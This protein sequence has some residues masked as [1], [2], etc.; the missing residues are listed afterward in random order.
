MTE[1]ADNATITALVC[2]RQLE[3]L[4]VSSSGQLKIWDLRRPEN[5][6]ARVLLMC[7][8]VSNC[9]TYAHT[10]T[11]TPSSSLPTFPSL[12][13]SSF[14]Q[15]LSLLT[16]SF[17]LSLALSSLSLLLCPP[18]Y[19][20]LSSL[21]P[22]CSSGEHVGLHCLDRHP[23]QPHLVALGRSDGSVG[24]WDLRQEGHHLQI[25]EAH[26]SIGTTRA[27]LTFSNNSLHLTPCL[28][29]RLMPSFV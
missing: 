24:F 28:A 15:S 20:F 19:P 10:H 7:V 23:H 22:W 29:L 16:P 17:P 6:A 11:H 21:S 25:I 26:N 18:P 4:S 13:Y 2:T 3:V 5:K 1:N 12:P 14:H 27:A 8:C 9:H